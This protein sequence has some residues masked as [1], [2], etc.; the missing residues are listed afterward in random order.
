[1]AEQRFKNTDDFLKLLAYRLSGRLDLKNVNYKIHISEADQI[2]MDPLVFV[3]PN[4]YCRK[5]TD[6]VDIVSFI[7]STFVRKE[8]RVFV[9][10]DY[11]YQPCGAS[12]RRRWTKVGGK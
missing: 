3:F 7:L 9:P 11:I 12:K 10:G 8:D 1:M 2:T 4:R 6:K 5:G